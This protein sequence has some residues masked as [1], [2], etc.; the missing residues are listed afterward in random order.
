MMRKVVLGLCF[1]AA[2]T[3]GARAQELPI[4]G[5][6]NASCSALLEGDAF[7]FD[8]ASM[9][10]YLGFLSGA[11]IMAEAL[12][13][14]RSDGHKLPVNLMKPS[15]ALLI[16]DARERREKKPEKWLHELGT[17]LIVLMQK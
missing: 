10:W 3:D 12:N 6:G 4:L 14:T 2:L 15:I 5:G 9:Q 16:K 17:D 1:I 8:H 13:K 7:S 11:A